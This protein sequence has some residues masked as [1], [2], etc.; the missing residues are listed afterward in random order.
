MSDV[1]TLAAYFPG[2]DVEAR[3]GEMV[4]PGDIG[5]AH[6]EMDIGERAIVID[7]FPVGAGPGRRPGSSEAAAAKR[8]RKTATRRTNAKTVSRARH[9]KDATPRASSA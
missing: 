3:R 1:G 9:A 6:G 2:D 4:L 7:R 5:N 8:M